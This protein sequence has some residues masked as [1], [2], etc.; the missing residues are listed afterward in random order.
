MPLRRTLIFF[1][2][3]FPYGNGETFIENEISY[4][5]ESFHKICICVPPG[6]A[7]GVARPV[8]CNVEVYETGPCPNV[9]L[10]ILT[11]VSPLFWKAVVWDLKRSSISVSFFQAFRVAWGVYAKA[12]KINKTVKPLF[13]NHECNPGETVLYSYWLDESALSS[14]LIKNDFPSLR[15]IS[16]AHRWDVYE[17]MHPIA[18]LPFRPFMGSRLS[19]IVCIAADNINYFSIR[20]PEIDKEKLRLS[21]LGT[22]PVIPFPF[23]SCTPFHIVSCSAVIPRK[24]VHLIAE[25]LKSSSMPVLWTH[26]GDG[27]ELKRIQEKYNHEFYQN[28]FVSV[29]FK[30]QMKNDEVRRFYSENKIDLFISLSESEGLPVSMME[31]Q[32]AGIPILSTDVGGVSEIVK[33]NLTGWL[34]PKNVTAEQVFSTLRRIMEIP[35]EERKKMRDYCIRYWQTHFSAAENYPQFVKILKGE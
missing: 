26:L 23:E 19:E 21:Y 31:A 2:A 29:D 17:N 22:L 16:R 10:R 3:G 25:S 12:L 4:L 13:T 9:W 32:S 8:P 33:E 5:A 27:Q 20:F 6:V 15:A 14:A 1:T 18:Y 35:A 28:P 34:L 24:R 11:L 30:G 7:K